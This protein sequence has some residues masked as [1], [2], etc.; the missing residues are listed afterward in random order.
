MEDEDIDKIIGGKISF[1]KGKEYLILTGKK[2]DRNYLLVVSLQEPDEVIIVE[3]SIDENGQMMG[4]KYEGENYDN[5]FHELLDKI[6]DTV[7]DD[8]TTD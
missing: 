4:R 1:G 5:I 7:F 6:T 3:F 2:I 8:L